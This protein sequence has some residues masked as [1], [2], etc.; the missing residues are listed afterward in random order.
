MVCDHQKW[1]TIAERWK[2]TKYIKPTFFTEGHVE[3]EKVYTQKCCQC[4]MIRK[5]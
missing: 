1:E 2:I 5:V 4:G 3:R